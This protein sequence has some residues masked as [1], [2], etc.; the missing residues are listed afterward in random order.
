M[1]DLSPKTRQPLA[2]AAGQPA[3]DRLAEIAQQILNYFE[4]I[5]AQARAQLAGER[6]PSTSSLA[7]INTLTADRA[8][9][10]LR[11]ISEDRLRT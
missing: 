6:G 2:P 10:N 7:V 9:Q 4:A 1:S 3:E 5:S 8:I 11:V